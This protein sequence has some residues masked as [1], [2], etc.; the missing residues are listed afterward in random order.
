[1][2]SLC[3][4]NSGLRFQPDF[5][6]DDNLSSND[7]ISS[8]CPSMIKFKF[9]LFPSVAVILSS[10]LVETSVRVALSISKV[11]PLHL[12]NEFGKPSPSN[13]VA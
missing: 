9:V 3:W 8:V 5:V 7:S 2:K 10:I 4:P 11:V 12:S 1:M 13:E 6:I